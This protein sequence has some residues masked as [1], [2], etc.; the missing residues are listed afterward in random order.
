[1]TC[2]ASSASSSNDDTLRPEYFP[3]ETLHNGLDGSILSKV[4]V[5]TPVF[6]YVPPNLV[7]LFISDLNGH[8]PSYIYRYLSEFY[9]PDDY[10]LK[11][12]KER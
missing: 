3:Q 1:M 7:T 6:E 12:V 4:H 5:T 2:H 9:H 11:M 10:D 8:G